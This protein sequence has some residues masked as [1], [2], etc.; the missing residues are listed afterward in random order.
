[1][2]QPKLFNGFK[3]YLMG[4][5]LQSYKG[6]LQDLITAAG[7]IILH[8]KPVSKD[9]NAVLSGSTCQTVIVYS[10]E[11]PEKC[12]PRKQDMI[13]NC[14]RVDAESLASSTGAKAASNLCV[15]N[16]IAACKLQILT[17]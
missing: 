11:L 7:G 2:Q 5:F 3:F 13:F 10:L 6:Y 15:L 1:M 16:A 4:D 12:D 14:R 17:E 8:R 9:Q